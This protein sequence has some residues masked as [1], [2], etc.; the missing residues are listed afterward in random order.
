MSNT[1]ALEI[2]L[3]KYNSTEILPSDVIQKLLTCGWTLNDGGKVSYLPLGDIDEYNWQSE[4]MDKNIFMK[5]AFEKEQRKE[6]VGV[7]LTWMDTGVGG[8]VLIWN[9]GNMIFD[10]NINRR[11]IDGIGENRITDFN[12][13]IVKLLP[14]LN[15]NGLIVE[16][17]KF[18]ERV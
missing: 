6:I 16:S 18:S 17:Y 14:A 4:I 10:L 13:Y 1:A 9:D 11:I 3:V 8:A 7:V 15:Q 5:I 12:W 2:K